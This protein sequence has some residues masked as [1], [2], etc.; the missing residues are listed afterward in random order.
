MDI[1]LRDLNEVPLPPEEV[2]L[3]ALRAEARPDGHRVKV[4][5]EIDPFQ[6]R[7]SL[8]VVILDARGEEMA[9]ASILETMVQ[10]LELTLHLR[11]PHPGAS[12]TLAATLYYQK[13]PTQDDE[14][15]QMPEPL[16]VDRSQVTFEIPVV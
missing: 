16:I 1:F 8:Q 15:S 3:R 14:L 13:L 9:Q 4:Y 10:K 6:K 5:I 7:P 12:Y 11:Q 2:R